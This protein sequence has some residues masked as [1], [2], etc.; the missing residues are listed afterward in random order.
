[1]RGSKREIEKRNT[2]RKKVVKTYRVKP[3]G[4]KAGKDLVQRRMEEGIGSEVLDRL[5]GRVSGAMG[6]RNRPKEGKN[7][8]E[9]GASW[10]PENCNRSAIQ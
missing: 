8:W 10:G 5:L 1:M 7:H 2:T 3:W 6:R 4:E 9:L